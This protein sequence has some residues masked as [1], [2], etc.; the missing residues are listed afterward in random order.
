MVLFKINGERNSGTRFLSKILNINGFPVYEGKVI[1]PVVY[2]WK[3]AIP[4]PD[5]KTLDTRVVDLFIF[6]N[7]EDWLVSMYKNP[8]HLK[9]VSDFATF[10]TVKQKACTDRF[11]LDYKTNQCQN[12]DD[13]DKTIFEIRYYKF[14]KIMEYAKQQKDVLFINLSY[15]QN[16]TNLLHFLQQLN[17]VYFHSVRPNYITKI[18]HTKN[19]KLIGGNREYNIEVA[20]FKPIIEKYKNEDIEHFIRNVRISSNRT[21]FEQNPHI[22]QKTR[23][24]LMNYKES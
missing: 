10:L 3:H 20:L 21:H 23:F 1:D 7:L 13:N 4:R 8:Y 22:E 5:V 18:P 6:R 16:E 14:Q 2:H 9:P 11:Y 19:D 15:L 12:M 24:S 17:K